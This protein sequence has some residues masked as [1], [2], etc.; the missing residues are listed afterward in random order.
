MPLIVAIRYL[1]GTNVFNT[2]LDFVEV[3]INR[4]S[5]KQTE[6]FFRVNKNRIE[7]IKSKLADERSRFIYD[8]L[9][10]YRSTHKR[11]YLKGIV[12]RHQYFDS[13]IIRL[14]NNEIFV[15]CG[16]YKGDTVKGFL[17]NIKRIGAFQEIIALEPDPYNFSQ[18]QNYVRKLKNNR[19]KCYNFGTWDQKTKVSLT[20]NTEEGCKISQDGNIQIKVDSLDNIL[21]NKNVTF[22]KMDIEGAELKSLEGAQEIIKRCY[23]KLAIS[24][25]HSDSDMIDIAEHILQNYPQY[26]IYIRHYTYFYADTVLYAVQRNEEAL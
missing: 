16:A 1:A 11:K 9:I 3:N 25:Y 8:S 5:Y 13:D 20:A 17:N 24:I 2:I 22:I 19:I 14:S 23:P 10:K 26:S 12:D 4:T 15:D 21:A 6:L 18:L 7:N